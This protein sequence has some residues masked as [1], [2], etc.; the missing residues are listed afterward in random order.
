MVRVAGA[1]AQDLFMVAKATNGHPWLCYCTWLRI[2][3]LPPLVQMRHS[4]PPQR[5]KKTVWSYKRCN[6]VPLVY[7]ATKS[8]RLTCISRL[9]SAQK[10]TPSNTTNIHYSKGGLSPYHL[11]KF[12]LVVQTKKPTNTGKSISIPTSVVCNNIFKTFILQ[13][14]LFNKI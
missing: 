8:I 2:Q 11:L 9:I 12:I 3:I 7:L 13:L 5:I 14:E 6:S 1:V 10:N 4:V